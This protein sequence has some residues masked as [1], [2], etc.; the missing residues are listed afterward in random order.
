MTIADDIVALVGRKRRLRL[1]EEDIADML[2]GQNRASQQR[3]NPACRRL[4]SEGRLVR[5][6]KGGQDD[7]Y[8][9]S[10]PKP[11]KLRRPTQTD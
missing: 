7:P 1:T 9:Y 3:V 10:L 11:P 4:V 6:G 2:Y 5:H 8:T